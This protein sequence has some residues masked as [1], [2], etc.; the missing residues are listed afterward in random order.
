MMERP[1]DASSSSSDAGTGG[2]GA[3]AEGGAPRQASWRSSVASR[4]GG[5]GSARM[6][7]S[8]TSPLNRGVAATAEDALLQRR[9]ESLAL[10][11]V[12]PRAGASPR[13]GAGRPAPEAADEDS[14]DDSSDVPR[15]LFLLSPSPL[16]PPGA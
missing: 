3:G 15:P 8:S 1:A 9:S 16:Q 10:G 7:R 14:S 5:G 11:A 13:R 12:A 2:G 4:L 6:Q